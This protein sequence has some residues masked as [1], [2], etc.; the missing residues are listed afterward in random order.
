MNMDYAETLELFVLRWGIEQGNFSFATAAGIFKTVISVI[1][2][3]IA[4]GIA[5]R[6]GEARLF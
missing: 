6:L 3:F 4:N 1:L 5:K 2:L